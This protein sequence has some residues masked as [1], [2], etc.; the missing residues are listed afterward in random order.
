L[1]G[2][3]VLIDWGAWEN[4]G[5][6][7]KFRRS[8]A[9]K[10]GKLGAIAVLIKSLTS[11]SLNTPHTGSMSDYKADPDA[12]PVGASA[13]KQ[14]HSHSH[15]GSEEPVCIPAACCTTEDAALI[16]RLLALRAKEAHAKQAAPEPLRIHLSLGCKL[17]PDAKSRNIIAEVKGREKPDEIVLLGAHMDSWDVGQGAHDDGQGC[18]AVW[19]A[20]RIIKKLGLTPRRTLRVVLFTDEEVRSSGAKAYKE[21]H[22]NELDKHVAA[23][24]TDAGAFTS[25]G[26]RYKGS[27]EGHGVAAQLA[28]LLQ[29]LNAQ[30]MRHTGETGVDIAP[31]V[32]LGV[33]G[34]LL[35]LDDEWW[36]NTY[37]RFHHTTADTFDKID[38]GMLLQ[39]TQVL[40]C[41]AYLLAEMP[42]T[43]HRAQ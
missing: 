40:A 15:D 29:P 16:K 42:S 10:A 27:G 26:Y 23:L 41:M 43:L 24:E 28:S 37:W 21:A 31:I 5:R 12:D 33:P 11:Y 38:K 4:Y 14:A 32:D 3:I 7:N 18:M 9:H 35:S 20:V 17:L 6:C 19:D 1:K 2:K 36:T 8:G 22:Q 39:N 25:N 30:Q 13:D 34:F